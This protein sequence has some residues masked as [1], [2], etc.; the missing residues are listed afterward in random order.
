MKFVDE[1]CIEVQAGNG[2][3][4]CL[5]FRR[6]RRVPR[7]GPDGGDGGDGGSLLL[8]AEESLG[9]LVDLRNHRR[10]SAKD[11]RRGGS[12]Q[13]HGRN[14]PDLQLQ[15]PVGTVV[16]DRDSGE[17]LGE[18]C[19]PGE[20]VRVVRG[21]RGGLGNVHF[22]SSVNRS[23][24]RTTLGEAGEQRRLRLVLSLL[25]D[26]G[27]LGMP[28]AGKSSLLS[29]ISAARPKVADYPFTTLWPN[30]GTVQMDHDR[31]FIA[32]DIPGL[33]A[34]AADGVGLGTRFL[35][36]LLRTR[37]LLHVVDMQPVDGSDPA[38]S[39]RQLNSEMEAFSPELARRECWLVPNKIDLLGGPAEVRREVSALCAAVDW[40]GE[41]MPIS[42][43]HGDGVQLLCQRLMQWLESHDESPVS[44]EIIRVSLRSPIDPGDAATAGGV[45]NDSA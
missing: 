20:T 8:C 43:L 26:V 42:A 13:C 10:Y 24:R 39:V 21:G 17:V 36:H 6:E 33:V 12:K 40:Q 4:G 1:L 15:V 5:S 41:V 2:G 28:N 34:G 9:T 18:L 7:G 16:Q 45:E 27:L 19:R 25:A 14:G 29:A 11:G 32:A 38:A 30:L 22:K 44:D 35:K 23:P 3:N 37:L 31:Y